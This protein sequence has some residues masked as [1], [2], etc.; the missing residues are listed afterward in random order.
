[1]EQQFVQWTCCYT[2]ILTFQWLNNHAQNRKQVSHF[3]IKA[4]SKKK[5]KKTIIPTDSLQFIFWVQWLIVALLELNSSY[6]II[7]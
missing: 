5:K 1:M 3:S 6:I 4:L 2:Y 7:S